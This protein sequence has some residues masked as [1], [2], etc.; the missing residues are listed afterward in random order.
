[1]TG[2]EASVMTLLMMVGRPNSPAI[3]GSGGLKRTIPRLPSRLSEHRGFF[4]ADIRAGAD[5]RPRG[6]KALPLPR[7]LSPR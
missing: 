3:A 1:M 5:A 4:A 2:T 6:R 7:M